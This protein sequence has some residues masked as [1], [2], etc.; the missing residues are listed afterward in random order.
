MKSGNFNWKI[1]LAC[2]FAIAGVIVAVRALN[3]ADTRGD[4]DARTALSDDEIAEIEA[5]IHRLPEDEYDFEIKPSPSNLVQIAESVHARVLEAFDQLPSNHRLDAR[6][7]ELFAAAAERQLQIMLSGS[8]D[9]WLERVLEFGP[10]PAETEDG[11]TRPNF[12]DEW[13]RHAA[14]LKFAPL[15]LQHLRI[16]PLRA[17]GQL[18]EYPRPRLFFMPMPTVSAK[19]TRFTQEQLSSMDVYQIYFPLHYTSADETSPN[20]PIHIGIAF[21]WDRERGRWAPHEMICYS[22]GVGHRMYSPVF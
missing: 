1:I 4:L 9:L 2:L 3:R 20:V 5:S 6:R 22:N 19:Y 12:R 16:R 17:Q 21:A 14:K 15:S 13:E 8:Y 7:E 11:S 10:H 18:I